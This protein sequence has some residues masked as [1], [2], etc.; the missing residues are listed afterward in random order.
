MDEPERRV[1]DARP[2]CAAEVKTLQAPSMRML[3][4]IILGCNGGA[5]DF[6][7]YFTMLSRVADDTFPSL[8]HPAIV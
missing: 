6:R 1:T 8:V 2:A 7:E 3:P 5:D 4:P